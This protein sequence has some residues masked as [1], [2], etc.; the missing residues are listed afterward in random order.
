MKEKTIEILLVISM[1]L[2]GI[3]MIA[4]MVVSGMAIVI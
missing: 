1:Y 3:A 2:L 4:F